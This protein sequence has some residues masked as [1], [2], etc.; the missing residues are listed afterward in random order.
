MATASAILAVLYPKKFTVY[1]YR[2]RED[3]ELN[4]FKNIDT[5]KNLEKRAERYLRFVNQVNQKEYEL[6]ITTLRGKDKFLW[7][8]SLYN[9]VEK[10]INDWNNYK[11]KKEST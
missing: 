6:E 10:E 8:R 7:G 1:D 9:Q 5:I 2:V 4:F 11:I 3:P